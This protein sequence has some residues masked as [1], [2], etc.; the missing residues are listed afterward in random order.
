MKGQ[1]QFTR[2]EISAIKGM[3]HERGRADPDRQKA[4][5]GK[6]CRLGFYI[7]D[8]GEA[9]FTSGHLDDLIKIGRIKVTD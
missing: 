1:T 9:G 2:D 6:M 8:Y 3:L 7:N 4:I 5:R